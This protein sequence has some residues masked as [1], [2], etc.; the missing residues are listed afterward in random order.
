VWERV[1]WHT[2]SRKL[3]QSESPRG[4]YAK[5]RTVAASN[6]RDH[7][8]QS[9]YYCLFAPHVYRVVHRAHSVRGESRTQRSASGEVATKPATQS[10]F[11]HCFKKLDAANGPYTRVM[12]YHR[13]AKTVSH[14]RVRVAEY[15][16]TY[17]LLCLSD[18]CFS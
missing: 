9:L 6:N 7:T 1:L 5:L 14:C 12:G 17:E 15:F 11:V 18:E 3:L 8:P 13:N 4:K 10:N 16:C 2:F